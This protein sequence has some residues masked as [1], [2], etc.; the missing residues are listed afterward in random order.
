MITGALIA[1]RKSVLEAVNGIDERFS[2]E[3]NDID[4]CL[5]IRQLGLRIVYNP[6]AELI[7]SEKKSRGETVPPGEQ[8]ALFLSR[9]QDWL[10]EDPALPPRMRRDMLDL[11]P[12][13]GRGEWFV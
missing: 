12:S 4:L 6:A 13:A 1:T 3:F 5:K 10:A 2:L 11:V 9:W 8:L 7:H